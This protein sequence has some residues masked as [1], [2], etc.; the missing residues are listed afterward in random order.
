MP[1]GRL[2]ALDRFRG[3]VMVLMAIDHAGASMDAE[4]FA[5]DSI[6]RWSPGSSIAAGARIRMVWHGTVE[7]PGVVQRPCPS[8]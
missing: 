1:T 4:H 6:L 8:P 3:F 5:T 7:E 2:L